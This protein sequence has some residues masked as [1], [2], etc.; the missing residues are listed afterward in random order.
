MADVF[1]KLPGAPFWSLLFFS[2][3]LSLGLGSQIG[4]LEGMIGPLFD[5]PMLKNVKK[6][7][8]TGKIKLLKLLQHFIIPWSTCTIFIGFACLFCASI[9]LLFTTGAGEYWL[10]LFDNYGAMGLTLIAFAE[11]MSVMYVYG[12]EKFTAV[13]SNLISSSIMNLNLIMI[14]LYQDLEEMTGV[15]PG[16]YWQLTWRF[17]A[18]IVL[19]VILVASIIFQLQASPTYSAWDKDEVCFQI[20]SVW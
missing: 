17:M 11:I 2:M 5:I 18:P 4:I 7:I 1:T 10:T 6:P 13:R 3:L 16:W 9:G 12:H 20:W 15:R 19:A 8:I 14:V